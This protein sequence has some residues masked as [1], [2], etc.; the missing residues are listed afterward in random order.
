MNKQSELTF[1]KSDLASTKHAKIKN[2]AL[3]TLI[4]NG[5][6]VQINFCKVRMMTETYAQ[7][8]IGNLIA[9]HGLNKLMSKVEFMGCSH[10][11]L[12]TLATV[13]KKRT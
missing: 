2:Q 7:H 8:F 9:K 4:D 3:S 10:E 5:H 11:V 6:T 1:D 12:K 13:A